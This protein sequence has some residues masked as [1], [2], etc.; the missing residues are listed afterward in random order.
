MVAILRWRYAV[1]TMILTEC[2]TKRFSYQWLPSFSSRKYTAK[3]YYCSRLMFTP[4]HGTQPQWVTLFAHACLCWTKMQSHPLMRNLLRISA[5]IGWKIVTY[6]GA[7]CARTNCYPVLNSFFVSSTIF[8][9]HHLNADPVQWL[10]LN[11]CDLLQAKLQRGIRIRD[12]VPSFGDRKNDLPTATRCTSGLWYHI[13]DNVDLAMQISSNIS[14][15][16]QNR[17]RL[18][19][20]PCL[21][22]W[23]L[24]L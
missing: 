5:L 15:T 7:R 21:F 12:S 2:L 24:S 19:A 11:K 6:Y 1:K 9:L 13:I 17:A 18:L 14:G 20:E 3:L 16:S 22:T 23:P 10:V 8:P 4:A